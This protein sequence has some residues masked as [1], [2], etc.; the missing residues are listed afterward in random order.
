M[1]I[2]DSPICD[3]DYVLDMADSWGDGWNGNEWTATGTTTG[4]VYGPFTISTGSS[5]TA[6]FTSADDCFSIICGGG[7]FASE[8]SWDLEDNSGNV[9]LSGGAPYDGSYGSC[10]F[11][12]TDPLAT[13]YDLNADIDDGSCTF[14]PCGAPA[15]I[16]QTFSTGVLPVGTCVPN[17]WAVTATVGSGWVFAGNP[18]YNASTT[19]GNNRVAG[20][21]TWIDFSGTDTDPVLEVE[22][23]DM[24]TTATP[25]LMFDYFSDLGTYSCAYNILHVEAF[26]GTTWNTVVSLQQGTI[27]WETFTYSLNGF[28]NGNIAEIRF[29]GESSGQSCDYYNDLLLDDVRLIDLISGC[30]ESTYSNYDA[31]ATIDDGSCANTYTL[32]MYDSF[33]D[34]WNGNTFAVS[35]YLGN[36]LYSE[37]I[38]TGSSGTATLSL[39][40]G[41]FTITCGGGSYTSEVS[42]TLDAPNGA[43][44]LSGGAPYT[45]SM[46]SPFVFGC[47][48]PIAINY[49]AT[50]TADDGSCSYAPCGGPATPTHETFSTG[51]LPVGTCV[52]NQWAI[53]AAAGDGW[54]FTGNPGY[55]ASTTLGN[56]RNQ[57][58]FAWIDFSGTDTD[59]VPVSYTHLTLPTKA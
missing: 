4:T 57:G 14:A 47:T 48:D 9:L 37:T 53:S 8:V 27:G 12:C 31:T 50:A 23:V 13:N 24:S 21:F 49:D 51:L 26:D 18:G 36:L 17:Q 33:G 52:P 25:T 44:V 58:E 30:T 20:E 46:C 32:Y 41:C 19:Q 39:G 43:T 38:S 1:C 34:G 22:D 45:G 6:N 7:S 54:R 42:W 56:N 15:P 16:H 11:G 3:V 29:R 40:D 2:R 28:L 5:A 35:D 55:N 59:P 10:A